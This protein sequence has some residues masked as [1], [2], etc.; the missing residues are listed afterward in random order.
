[1]ARCLGA[2][3]DA[4]ALAN[5]LIDEFG[6]LPAVLA[7][8]PDRVAAT[9]RGDADAAA[10]IACLEQAISHVLLF[11]A[12][13]RPLLSNWQQLLDYL[14][15]AMAYRTNECFRVLH[16]DVRNTLIRDEVVSEGTID[17][18]AVYVREIVKRALEVGSAAIILVH[19]HPSGD[20]TPSA[21]DRQITKRII[22]AGRPLGVAVHDHLIIGAANHFSMR[23]HGLL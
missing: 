1:M 22:D 15:A 20:T 10:A 3:S 11:R 6:S 19:N 21:A 14:R 13:E 18:A 12:A 2:R 16:L 7:A 4:L 9:T 23:A 5:R 8:A 17:Q